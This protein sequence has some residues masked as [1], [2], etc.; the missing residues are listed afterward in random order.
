MQ[1]FA[2]SRR[3][4]FRLALIATAFAATAATPAF[5]QDAVAGR[6]IL[7][8]EIAVSRQEATLKLEL[9]GGEAVEIALRDG[10]LL[11]GGETVASA[12]R[13]SPD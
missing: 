10:A 7:S 9:E 12:P 8:S 11:A 2:R 1:A 6:R 5:A 3:A 4:P 13:G